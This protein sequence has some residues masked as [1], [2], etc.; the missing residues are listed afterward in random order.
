MAADSDYKNS[1]YYILGYLKKTCIVTNMT[2]QIYVT[3]DI[4]IFLTTWC[5][6]SINMMIH[7]LARI[8]LKMSSVEKAEKRN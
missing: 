6:N 7:G 2:K 5:I 1:S 8:I 3:S 4:H